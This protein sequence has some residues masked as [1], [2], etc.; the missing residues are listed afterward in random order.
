MQRIAVMIAVTLLGFSTLAALAEPSARC[1]SAERCVLQSHA[2]DKGKAQGKAQ[3]K[4]EGAPA[5]NAAPPAPKVGQPAP[6]GRDPSAAELR[7][8]DK[9]GAGR[10]YRI[11]DDRVV[12]IDSG[13]GKVVRVLGRVADLLH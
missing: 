6:D 13:T 4:R 9:P 11:V 10:G 8:L 12:L 5:K 2:K 1:T 3:E 7:K